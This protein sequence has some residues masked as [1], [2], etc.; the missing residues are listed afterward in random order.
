MEG[1]VESKRWLSKSKSQFL[2]CSKLPVVVNRSK[3]LKACIK[4]S[5]MLSDTAVRLDLKRSSSAFQEVV[6]GWLRNWMSL[7]GLKFEAEICVVD[8]FC[9]T[10]VIYFALNTL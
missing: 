7:H 5:V 9:G 4:M 2:S 3:S 8:P 6:L 1:L 10:D